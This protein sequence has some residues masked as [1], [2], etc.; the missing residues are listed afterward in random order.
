MVRGAAGRNIGSI[1][2]DRPGTWEPLIQTEFDEGHPAIAPNGQW[3]AYTSNESG[4]Y[5]VYVQRYPDLGDRRQVSLGGGIHPVWSADGRE[6]LYGRGAP[7]DAMMRVT[8][9]MAANDPSTLSLGTPEVLFEFN[10]RP[11]LDVRTYDESLD[12]QSL[13][14]IEGVDGSSRFVEGTGRIN[15]VLNWHQELLERVPIP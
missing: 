9:E 10:Y 8:V 7:P 13:L 3:I 5:E 4:E 11:S 2:I 1:A 15:V 12:G 14:M 6:L